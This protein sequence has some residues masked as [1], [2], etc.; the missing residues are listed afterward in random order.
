LPKEGLER[1]QVETAMREH[2]ID[3]IDSVKLAVLETNGSISVVPRDARIIRTHKHVR[4]IR[5]R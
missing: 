4:E 2:G 1:A 3:S 5:R